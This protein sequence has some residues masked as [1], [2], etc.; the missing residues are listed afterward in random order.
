MTSAL[1]R[2]VY[3]ELE[4]NARGQFGLSIANKSLVLFIIVASALAILETEPLVASDYPDFFRAAELLFGAIFSVE[5]LLRLWIAPDNPQWA[6]YRFPRLR[7][8]FSV[9]AIIDFLAIVPTCFDTRSR[10]GH[11]YRWI[12]WN[13]CKTE[14]S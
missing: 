2:R 4:P 3:E 1:R 7:Y 8:A 10:C 6:K 11:R 13:W 5:Y 12:I 9:A 14:R